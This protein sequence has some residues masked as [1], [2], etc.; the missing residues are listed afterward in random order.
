MVPAVPRSQALRGRLSDVGLKNTDEDRILREWFRSESEYDSLTE[1]PIEE[2]LETLE[3]FLDEYV[4]AS[5][6]Y[7]D[8]LVGESEVQAR[9]GCWGVIGT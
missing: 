1:W 8:T 5:A 7:Q 4:S 2:F 3:A 9:L 6:E